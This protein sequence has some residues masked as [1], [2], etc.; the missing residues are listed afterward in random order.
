MPFS[1]ILVVTGEWE[2]L[3]VYLA[4][5]IDISMQINLRRLYG[6]VAQVFLHHAEIL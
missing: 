2:E 3:L 5:L 6:G 1:R 4:T